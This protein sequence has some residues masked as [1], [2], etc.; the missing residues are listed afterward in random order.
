[1]KIYPAQTDKDIE[2]VKILLEE[3]AGWLEGEGYLF[4]DKLEEFK[5]QVANLLGVFVPPEGYL[6]VATYRGQV[7]G[8]VAMRKL[9]SGLCEMR[10]LFVR[11]RY[12]GLN[13]GKALCEAIIA[14]AQSA[15]YTSMRLT[16]NR[17][18]VAANELYKALGFKETE[19]YADYLGTD[20]VFMELKLV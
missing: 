10:S 2:H 6:L 16:S 9:A 13:I 5:E 15:G 11:R 1:M 7:A 4:G 8:C 12:R 17:K 19:S 3:Y 18:M 20:V 14:K